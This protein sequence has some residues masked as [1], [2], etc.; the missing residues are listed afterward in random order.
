MSNLPILVL[1]GGSSSIKC[2]VYMAD[3]L[4]LLYEGEASGIGTSKARFEFH[5]IR[6]GVHQQLLSATR[7]EELSSFRDAVRKIA[8]TLD[9]PGVPRPAAIGHRVVHSGPK[10]TSHQR[11]T[12]EVLADIE[13]ATSFAPLHEPIALEIIR[14]AMHHFPGIENYACFDTIFHH[15]LPE[16]ASIYPL[17][18]DIREQ[19]VH[20][21]GFHGLSCESILQQLHDRATPGTQPGK[22]VPARLIVAHLGSGASVTAMHHGQSIDTTMGLTPCGGILMGTRPGDLDPG[23]IFFLLRMHA[24]SSEDRTDAVE[25]MLNQHSGLLALSGLSNDMRVLREASADGNSRANLAIDAFVFSVKKAIGGFGALMGGLDALVFTGGIGEHDSRTRSQVCAGLEVFGIAI[26][27]GQNN[28]T[29]P[30]ARLI[31]RQE[32]R[33]AVYVLPAQE[34]RMIARHIVRMNR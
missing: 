24:G 16:A 20:R 6:G 29:Q 32:S 2:S 27:S 22:P 12:P 23:L 14:E 33:V 34:D 3:S 1:N 30:K 4:T 11:I 7:P 13:Q 9:Q 28:I 5:A 17:P 26:D 15:G 19:G 25:R 18:K 10:L 8:E 21:Y 31:S